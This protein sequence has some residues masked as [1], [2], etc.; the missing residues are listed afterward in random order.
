MYRYPHTVL[1]IFC[2]TPELG[3][4]KTRLMPELSAEE[5]LA[6]HLELSRRTL[7]L[8]TKNR[9]CPIELWCAPTLAHPFFTE[10]ARQ[11]GV[12]LRE[13]QGRDLGERMRHALETALRDYAS[14]VLI[15][16]DCPS[17]TAR[18]IEAAIVALDAHNHLVFAPAE[19]GGYVLVGLNRPRPEV[20]VEMPWGTAAVMDRTRSRLAAI[21]QTH[22]ELSMQWDVDT[23]ADFARYRQPSG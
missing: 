23:A 7:S 5:A 12:R 21:G 3:R 4:V 10:A 9:L 19:D 1:Q 20:F 18:D 17:L 22:V 8:A 13:Q 11:Y 14:A 6:A 15:G 2:K 16:T